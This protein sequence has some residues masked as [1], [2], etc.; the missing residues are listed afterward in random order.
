MP[1]RLRK[2]MQ[3]DAQRGPYSVWR[4]DDP[5]AVLRELKPSG[6]HLLGDSHV[7]DLYAEQ[8]ANVPLAA[9]AVKL[10][11]SEAAKSI[12][13]VGEYVSALMERGVRRDHTLVAL[14]GGI[15]QDIV[16]F[17]ATTLFRGMSWEFV[18][19]TLLAQADSCI[20][21]KSSINAAAAKNL[22]GSFYPPMKVV[23]ASQFLQT[24]GDHDRRSGVGEMLK[25][26]IIDG[27]DSF[28]LINGVYDQL[29]LKPELMS[30]FITR[31]LEIKK[32]I[33][34]Q[35]EFDRGPRNVM[36]YGHSFGHAIE[37]GTAFAV[38]HGIAVTI[39]MDMAN[40]WAVH[41][42]R[43]SAAA[44]DEMRRVLHRNS[45][46]FGA[47]AVDFP[48]FKQALGRDKKNIG[49]DL[50]LI[51]LSKERRVEKVRVKPSPEFWSFCQ[52]YLSDGLW[53]EDGH[54]QS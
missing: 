10:E 29:F 6:C 4:C 25:V 38:P 54:D 16:C 30:Q 1:T 28:A 8:L 19:T 40:A 9:N 7:L 47:V 45:R 2:E 48:A 44:H 15:I 53:K 49:T 36:N 18:P 31:S 22:L 12:E 41:A 23:L 20:G 34:E 11:A 52:D 27:P 21:S 51:L 5:F 42:G 26:H 32:S 13:R 33:I 46:G 3:I 35:D 50:S 43:L 39:G 17:L 14:G 37:V 24:L